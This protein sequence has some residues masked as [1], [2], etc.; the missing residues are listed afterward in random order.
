MP[1]QK[2]S[3]N[4]TVGANIK[5]LIAAGHPRDQAIAIALKEAGR[6][7]Q[8]S[9][10]MDLINVWFPS[11]AV[12]S[13]D[14]EGDEARAG[15]M[16]AA[17]VPFAGV[18]FA[19]G[20]IDDAIG[21]WSRGA[22][23]GHKPRGDIDFTPESL[24]AM[25]DHVAERGDKVSICQDHKSAFVATTGQP[26]PSLGFFY[27]LAV[28]SDG[29][30]VKH[31]AFDNGDAPAGV[32]D[33]GQPRDGLYCRLGEITPLG[34]D[35]LQ[36]LANYSS[37]SPMFLTNVADEH[38]KQVPIYLVDFAATSSPYQADCAIQFRALSGAPTEGPKASETK[39]PIMDDLMKKL[40]YA[41][42]AA[43]TVDEKMARYAQH[44]AS[45][46]A[47]PDDV[48][49]MAED[50]G[51]HEDHEGAMKMAKHFAK[52]AE[53]HAEPDADDITRMDVDPDNKAQN[54]AIHL[55]TGNV[56]DEGGRHSMSADEKAA[57]MQAM[58]ALA[59]SLKARGVIV[60]D[61]ASRSVLMSLA[62]MQP[63]ALDEKAIAAMVDK[64]IK[65]QRE[66]DETAAKKA[67]GEQLITMARNAKAPAH[68]IAALQALVTVGDLNSARTAAKKYDRDG[69]HAHLFSRLTS[70]GAPIG[71]PGTNARSMPAGGS[72]ASV[73]KTKS[74]AV[75][76]SA[77]AQLADKAKEIATSKDPVLMSRLDELLPT[78]GDRK[79]PAMRLLKAQQLAEEMYP[80]LAAEAENFDLALS[81]RR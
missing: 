40:G 45:G 32:D 51:K 17:A 6:S 5:E 66:K 54:A 55:K 18:R 10:L 37:L 80:D 70:Q 4:A 28:L 38:G 50:L 65:A 46:D 2:G 78:E 79:N 12:V 15:A 8:D 58:S 36:G 31:W 68:E 56:H 53:P 48:K 63:P 16:S 72:G 24:A 22:T 71:E 49:A 67:E 19:I 3:D 74:G 21:K 77:D 47:S 26:A 73:T 20:N 43:P 42:G 13:M 59:A 81:V 23:F 14:P 27:A 11:G 33:Q 62:A 9:A 52:F 25:V 44:F 75:I 60:P 76:M 7:N 61:K 64:Q 41:E 39:G 1:L 35:P 69:Q 30:L 57:E 29:K 34:A